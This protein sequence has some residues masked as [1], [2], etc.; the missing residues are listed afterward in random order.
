MT[1]V[2]KP[3]L[4]WLQSITCNGNTHSFFAHNDFVALMDKFEVI[5]HPIIEG[6]YT[7]SD[8]VNKKIGCDVLIL[9][10]AFREVGMQKVNQEIYA[11]AQQYGKKA[12][13]IITAGSCATFGGV[14]SQYDKDSIGG[15][16]FDDE[17]PN[18]NYTQFKKKL[19]SIPGCPAHPRWIGSVLSMIL[20]KRHISLDTLH[21]PVEIYSYNAHTGC[22]R[23]EYFEWKIDTKGYGHK[24]GCLF[25]ENGCQAPYTHANCNK[26]LWND[27]STKTR[28]G[29][30]CFGC[31]EPSFPKQNLWHTDTHMGIPAT[32]PMGVPK[33]AYLTFTG[34]AKSFTIRRLNEPL[35]KYKK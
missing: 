30:P 35:I 9:E 5:Y 7:L 15:F 34:I 3:K 4:L 29:T 10:G 27:V 17:R 32:M 20:T 16:C 31:T 1:K 8:I 6:R 21:R 25:Y 2:K 23:N 33:R 26:I 24:E 13:W 22:S 18:K 14:L 12:K 19:I 11:L 28:V